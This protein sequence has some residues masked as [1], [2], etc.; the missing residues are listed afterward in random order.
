VMTQPLLPR[1]IDTRMLDI[2][3]ERVSRTALQEGGE[4]GYPGRVRKGEPCKRGANKASLQG[5][6]SSPE[7]D[8]AV[9]FTVPAHTPGVG[10]L[11]QSVESVPGTQAPGSLQP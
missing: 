5:S 10:V 1:E 3:H 9:S 8:S 7:D 2:V 6:V 11:P 4:Q